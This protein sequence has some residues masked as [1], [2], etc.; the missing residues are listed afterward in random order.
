MQSEGQDNEEAEGE[1]EGGAG[2]L[3]HSHEVPER[4]EWEV[5]MIIDIDKIEKKI[6]IFVSQW[7][8][9]C[10][11]IACE[12]IKSGLIEGRAVYGHYYG[13]VANTGKWDIR[14]PFQRHGW[15]ILDDGR[16]YDPTR[17]GFENNFP[18][19]AIFDKDSV[20]FKDYDEGGNRYRELMETLP[21][22]FDPDEKIINLNFHWK[23]VEE[24]I[25]D[26]L[27]YPPAVT[28]KMVMWIAN[29][30]I[31][32]LNSY[33]KEIYRAICDAGLKAFIPIDNFNYIAEKG[34]DDEHV[35]T[36]HRK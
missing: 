11:G 20:Q 28:I 34:E 32:R 33:E 4:G 13:E 19:I 8:G 15:I 6:N 23:E 5:E 16:I 9:N 1:A 30:S 2:D 12:I 26:L 35:S 7:N 14:R 36:R 25:D 24:F 21:P 22:E 3:F 17:W 18:Y 10:Y 31:K 27:C 29:L